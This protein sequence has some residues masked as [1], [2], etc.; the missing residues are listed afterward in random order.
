MWGTRA[1]CSRAPNPVS[2]RKASLGKGRFGMA[3]GV[4]MRSVTLSALV[5]AIALTGLSGTAAAQDTTQ[6]PGVLFFEGDIVRH[7][8][9]DQ[10]GPWCVLAS[11]FKRGEGIAWRMRTMT[12]D[13]ANA[14][15]SVIS[16]LVVELGNGDSF[17]LRYGPHGNPP[18]DFFWAS[19]YTIPE[20][21]PTGSLGYK[22]LATMNDGTVVTWEPFTRP[23]SLLWVIEGE[24]EMADNAVY[25]WLPSRAN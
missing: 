16:S 18:T 1:L 12:P 21:Y 3:K 13:G 7:S 2:W 5:F 15:D 22:V 14:D 24:P 20:S 4:L 25:Q 23:N 17:P 19:S 11:R 8:L 10:I 9:D 6:P